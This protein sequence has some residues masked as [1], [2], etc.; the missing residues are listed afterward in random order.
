MDLNT[1]GLIIVA[2]IQLFTALAVRKS[3]TLTKQIEVATSPNC[4]LGSST[5]ASASSRLTPA[6]S[7]TASAIFFFSFRNIGTLFAHQ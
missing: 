4:P 2:I 3:Y 5:D 7:E 6:A 1:I